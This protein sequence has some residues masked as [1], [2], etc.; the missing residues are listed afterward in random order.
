MNSPNQQ[1]NTTNAHKIA[2]SAN[3][4]LPMAFTMP[5]TVAP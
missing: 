2:A 3:G 1:M 5:N 4:G